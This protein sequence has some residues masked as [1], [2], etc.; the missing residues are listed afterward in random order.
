MTGRLY[1]LDQLFNAYLLA[2]YSQG[3]T[4]ETIGFAD[5]LLNNLTL[6]QNKILSEN[7]LTT[8][9]EQEIYHYLEMT[10]WKRKY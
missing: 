3:L 10:I 1:S 4:A 6:L 8:E 7:K 5:N 2:A 9:L